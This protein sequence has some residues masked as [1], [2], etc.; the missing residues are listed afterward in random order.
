MQPAHWAGAGSAHHLVDLRSRPAGS[1]LAL[2]NAH[3][4][5]TSELD[6]DGYDRL[7]AAAGFAVATGQGPDAF[8]IAFNE[9]SVHDNGNLAWFRERHDRFCYV[10][11][12][13]VAPSAR[14]RGLARMLYGA[15]FEQARVE[16]R[17][18]VGCEINVVPPNHGS[19]ALHAALGF[20]EIGRR[21]LPGGKVIRYMR[22]TL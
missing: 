19:D 21:D 8:M 10:D 17:L 16:G 18:V 12:V 13:I 15:L 6:R 1:V 11:R 4:I 7:L 3:R 20:S 9:V 2:N 5:E 14:G 22:L